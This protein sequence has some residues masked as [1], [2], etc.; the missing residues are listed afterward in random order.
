MA[1]RRKEPEEAAYARNM[2]VWQPEESADSSKKRV[3]T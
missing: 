3:E 1:K 2:D